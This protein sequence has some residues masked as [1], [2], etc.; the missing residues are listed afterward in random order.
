VRNRLYDVQA[1]EKIL[2][3]EIPCSVTGSWENQ[4]AFLSCVAQSL[5]ELRNA[6]VITDTDKERFLE[7]AIT[8]FQE[9]N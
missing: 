1:G 6:E 9:E 5:N 4:G 3:P 7:S 8:A 2:F